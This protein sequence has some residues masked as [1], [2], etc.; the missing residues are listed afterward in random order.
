[1]SP[2]LRFKESG[3]SKEEWRILSSLKGPAQIQD[4]LNNLAFN[5]E[6]EGHRNASVKEVLNR[7]E[8]HCFEGALLA[9]A[10][11]WIKGEKPLILDLRA[12]K[13][14]SDHVVSLFKRNGCW[15][16]ISKTNHGVLRYREPVYK[17]IRELALSYFHEYFL[18]KDG[19]KTLR[20]FSKPFDLSKHGT[21]WLNSR[22]NLA[23]LAYELDQSP[24]T[25]ILKK[26]QAKTLRKADLIE[27]KM[28]EIEE[29]K[30]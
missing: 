22:E 7:R 23:W 9:A 2:K 1:M 15:G 16:A 14:D 8:A 19:T 4:F 6:K 10:T 13:D 26:G 27:R 3:L 29:W 21:S 20:S 18:Q 11:L 25:E 28:G 24:H 17:T 5:F 30:S 12:T